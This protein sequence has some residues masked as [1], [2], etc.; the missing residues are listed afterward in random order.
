MNT[1]QTNT[2]VN[3]TFDGVNISNPGRLKKL[4]ELKAVN[5]KLKIL[6]SVGGWGAGR[7]SEMAADEACRK[8]FA[9]NSGGDEVFRQRLVGRE[10]AVEPA[11]VEERNHRVIGQH[12]E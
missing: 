9:G 7:F 2:Q 6:L 8:K 1:V 11:V 4:S 3:E 5:P 12:P 10:K